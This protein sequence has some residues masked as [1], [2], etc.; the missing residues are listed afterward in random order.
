[1]LALDRWILERARV[2]QDDII[3]AYDDYQFHLVYQKIHNFCS[4][5][6]SS[7]Y[8]DIIKDRQYTTPQN[9]VAR[10]SAQT[11]LYHIIE[12]L[13]RWLSPI[14]SFTAEEIWQYIPGSRDESVF[15]SSWYDKFPL[16]E[17]LMN[18]DLIIEVRNAVNKELEKQRN[19]GQIGSALEAE[20]CLYCSPDSS[21]FSL[22]SQLEDELRFILITSKTE[23]FSGESSDAVQEVLSNGESL[24]IIAKPSNNPKCTRCWHRRP[25]SQLPEY[26]E[27]C[28]RCVINIT[29]KE[30]EERNYA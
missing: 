6:L 22:L 16:Q 14:L 27:I 18:W 7:F 5:E 28:D 11:A 30:G 2:L 12:A 4:L 8:L 25:L 20:V 24:G 1:M 13:V 21:L 17:N 15:L 3:K 10:R 9:S 26:S 19:E 29:V 23:L